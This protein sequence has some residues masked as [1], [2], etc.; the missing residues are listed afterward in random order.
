MI[1]MTL[2]IGIL[3]KYLTKLLSY[4][5]VLHAVTNKMTL[6]KSMFSQISV[7]EYNYVRTFMK[8]HMKYWHSYI[9]II[10]YLCVYGVLY[11]K[12]K[13]V[14]SIFHNYVTNNIQKSKMK[15]QAYAD[16]LQSKIISQTFGIFIHESQ[17]S[18]LL[19]VLWRQNIMKVAV[20]WVITHIQNWNWIPVC[21]LAGIKNPA[22]KIARYPFWPV[23]ILT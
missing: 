20:I 23:I 6:N 11:S 21:I 7:L 17:K 15:Q 12:T 22:S 16:W 14:Y 5:S 19:S 4:R 8:S 9:K 13:K 10:D 2:Y 3:T 18:L 1:N